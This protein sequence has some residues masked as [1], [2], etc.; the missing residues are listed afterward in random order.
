MIM[1]MI[2][3]T[4]I[5][6]SSSPSL[7]WSRR[8]P[9]SWLSTSYPSLSPVNCCYFFS[10]LDPVEVFWRASASSQHR[11]FLYTRCQRYISF[12]Y[13]K[14]RQQRKNVADQG[15]LLTVQTDYR[16]P[17]W[18]SPCSFTDNHHL[19]RLITLKVNTVW[20][21]WTF[22]V[23]IIA[24]PAWLWEILTENHRGTK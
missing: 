10:F 17:W 8:S 2:T 21:D 22:G 7:P 4:M 12:I 3:S 5:T 16:W 24:D 13:F 9:S 11:C 14:L 18:S 1:I 15:R 6:P 20:T 19:I 23:T